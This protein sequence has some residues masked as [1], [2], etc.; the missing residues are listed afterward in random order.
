I[1]HVVGTGIEIVAAVGRE[2]IDGAALLERA[3]V[4]A[5]VGVDRVA[6]V[7]LLGTLDDSVPAARG[8]SR[9]GNPLRVAP[10]AGRPRDAGRAGAPRDGPVDVHPSRSGRANHGTCGPSGNGL[11]EVVER[12]LGGVVEDLQG[13]RVE[14]VRGRVEE[15]GGTRLRRAGVIVRG[16]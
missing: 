3:V 6:V 11:T 16:A 12:V 1:E 5:V 10:R 4:A 13:E 8:G 14:R 7:T 15:I 2:R 9:G